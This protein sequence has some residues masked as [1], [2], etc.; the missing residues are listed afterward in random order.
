MCDAKN[1]WP[2][3]A[4]N[5]AFLR[6]LRQPPG[7]DLFEHNFTSSQELLLYFLVL[8]SLTK[9]STASQRLLPPSAVGLAALNV[10]KVGCSHL[11]QLPQPT[12]ATVSRRLEG[13]HATHIALWDWV[14]PGRQMTH[15]HEQP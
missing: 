10:F 15:G 4:E 8:A 9:S 14:L 1:A 13:Q 6:V 12:A 11:Q 2:S 3:Q 5:T 7:D